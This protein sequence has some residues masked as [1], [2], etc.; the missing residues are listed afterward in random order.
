MRRL[1]IF[2]NVVSTKL[3]AYICDIISP[4]R[5][6]QRLS[7]TFNSLSLSLSLS[8]SCRTEYF[9]NSFFPCVI[10]EWNKLNPAVRRSGSYNIFRKSI[11]NFIRPSASK[12][13][14]INDANSIVYW[15]YQENFKPVYYYYFF[16]EKNSHAKKH[17]QA[18][19][20][21]QNKIKQTPNN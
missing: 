21:L 2:Y 10:G 13:Y 6:S 11:L 18:N 15:G 8:L 14:N 3:P 4:V 5:Q 20:N 19:I 1:C 12:V 7:N 17:S 9:K 16:Y